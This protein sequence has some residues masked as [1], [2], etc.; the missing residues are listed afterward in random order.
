MIL[1]E[2]NN[3]IIEETLSL[4]FDGASNGTKPE[5]LD[6]TFADF[7]GVLYH[8][9][10][11]N[12]EK[13]KV[14]VSISLKFYKE[15]QEHGADE[16]LKRIYG[17]FL[18]STEDG[19]NVS[20]LYDL[21]ALPAN[22]EEVIHQAGMLKRNCFASVFEKYFK[23]QEEGKEGEERAVVLHYRDDESMYHGVQRRRR[24]LIGKVFMQEF[25]EG[26]RASH[27]APQ[28]LFNHREPPLELKDTDAAVGDNIGY[29]TFVLFPRHTNA[30]ARD[31]TI[32]LIHTFRDYLHYHIKVPQGAEPR[33]PRRREEGDEDHVWKDVLPLRP[34]HPPTREIQTPV[35]TPRRATLRLKRHI[36]QDASKCPRPAPWKDVLPLRPAHPPTR[37]I[38]TPVDTP[39]RATLRLKRHIGQDASKCP[40]PAPVHV[41]SFLFF[42]E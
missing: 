37:E 13:T 39:R 36:G 14:M 5:G 11:P 32:N 25:K 8:I 4:K 24:R 41:P 20:L 19:Y 42:Y 12:G 31:N 28:V 3:R 33:S 35:D 2:I 34:A 7:D 17:D 38:Q 10:N 18:V 22:K 23:F 29:I 21:D 1:L 16:L 40:R 30:N 27:T 26:R 6:V 15:L 9:S